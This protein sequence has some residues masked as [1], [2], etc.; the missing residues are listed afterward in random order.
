MKYNCLFM[1]ATILLT[2]CS[3]TVRVHKTAASDPETVLVTY[4]IKPGKEA[5]FEALLTRIWQIYRKEHLVFAEPHIIVSATDDGNKPRIVEVLTWVSHDAPDHAPP[6]VK[7]I[8]KQEH[9]LCEER[10]GHRGIEG[11]EVHLVVPAAK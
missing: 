5:E 8:W 2:G 10:D 1:L 6:A 4:H 7:A 9:E 3:T 11:G